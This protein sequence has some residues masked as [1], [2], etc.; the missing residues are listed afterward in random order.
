M[1]Y[2]LFRVLIHKFHTESLT[3][4]VVVHKFSLERCAP[5]KLV[6]MLGPISVQMQHLVEL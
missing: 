1:C 6:D 4:H 3:I 2:L 5:F